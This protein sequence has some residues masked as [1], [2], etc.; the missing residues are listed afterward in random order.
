MTLA[1]TDDST[2][3]S[4]GS[5]TATLA[6]GSG[7]TV[8]SPSAQTVTVSDDD[9]PVIVKQVVTPVVSI[10]GGGGITEG[11]SASFTISANPSPTAEVDVTV[12]VTQ[13]GD[14]GATTGQ[15]TVRITSGSTT[16]TF[17]VSTT[18]DA[19]DESDGSI[20]VTINAGSG[21]TG[22]GSATVAVADNDD[23]PPTPV[24]SI[25]GGGG[26]TEGG[27]VSFTLTASPAPLA[28]LDVTVAITPVGDYG[29]A[30]GSRTVTIPTSGSATLTLATTDDSTDEGDGSVT[31]T[32]VDGADYDLEA[33]KTATVAVADDDDPPPPVDG[34]LPDVATLTACEDK[35]ELLISSPEASRSD[36]TVDFTVMLSCLPSGSQ[37]ILLVPVR[38]GIVGENMFISLSKDEPLT[39]VTVEIGGETEL[40]LAIGW[41]GG[42][43]SKDVQGEVVFT[44]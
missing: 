19:T 17:T 27:S 7:Y 8:G 23:P 13:S 32:L 3:E 37:M 11:G 18:D 4:D 39:T 41:S 28:N 29:V 25:T 31:A 43:K 1:T 26:V 35:P 38:D 10:T 34:D 20:T 44:D 30:A 36:A 5:V 16:A 42:L 14:F 33:S 2:D 12:T 40:G 22:S 21:Y 6:T 24:V 15:R 9:D